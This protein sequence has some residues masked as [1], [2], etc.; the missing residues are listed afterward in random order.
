MELTSSPPCL[1]T[2][3]DPK[4]GLSVEALASK[5][6]LNAGNLARCL[7][8]LVS[9]SVFVETSPVRRFFHSSVSRSSTSSPEERL[10]EQV[11]SHVS[12]KERALTIFPQP[13]LPRTHRA[14][15]FS[16]LGCARV[17][18]SL[19]GTGSPH[20]RLLA[21][22]YSGQCVLLSLPACLH[23]RNLTS[24]T[25]GYSRAFQEKRTVCEW[26]CDDPARFN[27]FVR[28]YPHS[29]ATSH[30]THSLRR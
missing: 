21:R 19:E 11:S 16:Q 26:V 27:W 18:A 28:C 4:I 17:Q 6:S 15:R 29:I 24:L 5:T 2:S 23:A 8:V 7:R 1:Y 14:Q 13:H 12:L 22:S 25:A 30:P 20:A 3:V 10:C 9:E